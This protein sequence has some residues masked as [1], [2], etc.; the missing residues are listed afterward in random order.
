MALKRRTMLVTAGA[1][2]A[3]LV[4]GGTTAAFAAGAGPSA[5]ATTSV[6]APGVG[7]LLGAASRSLAADLQHLGKDSKEHRA[8]DRADIRKKA[9]AGGYGVRIER[10]ARIVAGETGKLP[11]TLPASLKADL[12]TLR[13]DAKGS[14]A[15]AAEAA[16]IWKKALAGSYGSTIESL[17]KDAK[18]R[19][20]QRCAARTP[21]GSG[22]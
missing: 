16:A 10:V 17:A 20:D 2:A 1:T 19:V 3:V 4:A 13:S 15:R 22:S 12:K 8:A 14:D 9:L 7:P 18:A 21:D 6:C 5:A 11:S